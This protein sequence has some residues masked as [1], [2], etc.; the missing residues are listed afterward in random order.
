MIQLK[1]FKMRWFILYAILMF[2]GIIIMSVNFP[3]V[4]EKQ[5]WITLFISI[6]LVLYVFY[7]TK[8]HGFTYSEASLNE[9]MTGARWTKYLSL[10]ASLSISGLYE[11]SR[12]HDVCLF[13]I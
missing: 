10:T 1:Q 5:E 7:Q 4:P 8:K 11:W 6:G 12:G 2:I 9:G 3:F 13:T